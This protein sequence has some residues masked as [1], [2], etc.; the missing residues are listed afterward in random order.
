MVAEVVMN[1]RFEQRV[2]HGGDGWWEAYYSPMG[3]EMPEVYR[4]CRAQ[5]GGPDYLGRWTNFNGWVR[6]RNKAD[7]ML[8]LL[9][10]S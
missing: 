2:L 9:R 10:W 4:W 3:D 5:F 7:M 1:W 6:F 8:F